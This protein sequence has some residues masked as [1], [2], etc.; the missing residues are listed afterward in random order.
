MIH[1]I[2]CR[3][4]GLEAISFQ[5]SHHRASKRLPSLSPNA[6]SSVA[7]ASSKINTN[8]L[9]GCLRQDVKA[10]PIREK[11]AATPVRKKSAFTGS[12]HSCDSHKYETE[13][14]CV[15]VTYLFHRRKEEG[16]LLC[17]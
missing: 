2:S 7:A 13:L 3:S 15:A 9:S 12:N 1:S 11:S 4:R 16:K 5:T 17:L 14:G 10:S 6:I 8:C